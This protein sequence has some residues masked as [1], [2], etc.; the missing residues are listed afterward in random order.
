MSCMSQSVHL[1]CLE[2]TRTI[3]R[4][5][6]ED[7]LDSEMNWRCAD[8]VSSNRFRP[9]A[10][11]EDRSSSRR[12]MEKKECFRFDGLVM[13]WRRAVSLIKTTLRQTTQAQL[14]R[15][16]TERSQRQ[17]DRYISL[18][19]HANMLRWVSKKF[20]GWTHSDWTRFKGDGKKGGRR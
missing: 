18:R 20:E 2:R 16:R 6:R 15:R 17:Q 12:Y 7:I 9:S 19:L 11:L 4:Q 13:R 14:T 10:I 8:C 5:E 1:E 3:D